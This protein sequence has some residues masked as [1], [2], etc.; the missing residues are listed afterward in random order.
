MSSASKLFAYTSEGSSHTCPPRRMKQQRVKSC[1]AQEPNTT[2][3]HRR[4]WR[5]KIKSPE[6]IRKHERQG[7]CQ[8]QI[9]AGFYSRG[10]HGLWFFS[11]LFPSRIMNCLFIQLNT[12]ASNAGDTTQAASL[13]RSPETMGECRKRNL[14][15]RQTS[16]CFCQMRLNVTHIQYLQG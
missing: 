5:R 10:R 15:F 9:A 7:K 2:D 14:C 1:D 13:C 11:C 4:S 8:K 6:S 16:F 12:N 3:T